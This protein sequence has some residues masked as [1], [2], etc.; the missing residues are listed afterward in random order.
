MKTA[1]FFCVL[2][3]TYGELGHQA[4]VDF[5]VHPPNV[6]RCHCVLDVIPKSNMFDIFPC[7]LVERSLSDSLKAAECSGFALRDADI[8]S[9]DTFQGVF[10]GT[11]KR[12][13]VSNGVRSLES[14]EWT[15]S[16]WSVG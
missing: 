16:I 6:R 14:P 10:A 4:E 11:A 13:T 3:P 15:T 1:D 9:S 8:E 5:N 12:F 2:L 7:V